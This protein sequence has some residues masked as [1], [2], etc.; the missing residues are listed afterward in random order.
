MAAVYHALD[1]RAG[2]ATYSL[3]REARSLPY[4]FGLQ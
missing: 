1:S 2:P 4:A 3:L